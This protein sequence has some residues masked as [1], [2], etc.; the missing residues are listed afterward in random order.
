MRSVD[1]LPRLAGVYRLV[2]RVVEYPGGVGVLRVGED[3][4][5]VPGPALQITVV[6]D[7]LPCVAVVVGPEYARL[8]GLDGGIDATGLRRADRNAHASEWHIRQPLVA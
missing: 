1:L 3:V 5:V 4:L 6:G 7:E 2:R 8:L